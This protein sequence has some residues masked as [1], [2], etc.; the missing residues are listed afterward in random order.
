MVQKI[1]CI[2]L[3]VFGVGYAQQDRRQSVDLGGGYELDGYFARIAYSRLYGKNL[4]RAAGQYHRQKFEIA[5]TGLDQ[6]AVL[7]VL[8]LEYYHQILAINGRDIVLYAGG[9]GLGGYENTNTIRF[10]N[11]S[12]VLGQGKVIY[13]GH[14]GVEIEKYVAQLNTIGSTLGLVVNIRQNYVLGS[15]LGNTFFNAGLGLKLNF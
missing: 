4:L 12:R 6:T 8:N 10:A 9:G 15:D 7:Y 14:L 11:N 5:G 3:F 1:T 2:L 13:G